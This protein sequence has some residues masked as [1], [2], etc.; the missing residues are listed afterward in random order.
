MA[1]NIQYDLYEKTNFVKKLEPEIKR[2]NNQK[3][4]SI[5]TIIPLLALGGLVSYAAKTSIPFDMTAFLSVGFLAAGAYFH[6]KEN[7]LKN[8]FNST[9]AE[10][11]HLRD[12]EIANSLHA[13][14]HVLRQ[15]KKY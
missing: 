13:D 10:I 5:A 12:L 3:F 8:Q 6:I 7:N 1:K 9:H 4:A 14:K 15:F 2:T 11:N